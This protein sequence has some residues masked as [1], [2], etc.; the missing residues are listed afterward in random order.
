[1]PD[2]SAMGEY[3]AATRE[4][5]ALRRSKGLLTS[6]YGKDLDMRGFFQAPGST[7]LVRDHQEIYSAAGERNTFFADLADPGALRSPPPGLFAEKG[8]RFYRA[9][10]P[11]LLL[12]TVLASGRRAAC[13]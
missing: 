7:C 12:A 13:P 2:F 4:Y 6:G 10:A 8:E 11:N 3:L 1:M 5:L 9:L